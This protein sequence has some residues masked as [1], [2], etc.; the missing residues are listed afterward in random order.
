MCSLLLTSQ[1]FFIWTKYKEV[2][3][4]NSALAGSIRG[5]YCN[6]TH[7]FGKIICTEYLDLLI[8]YFSTL[9]L[10][11]KSLVLHYFLEKPRL[12]VTT[13]IRCIGNVPIWMN[14]LE[15][16]IKQH[17][18]NQSRFLKQLCQYV[19]RVKWLTVKMYL[20]LN[21]LQ[22]EVHVPLGYYDQLDLQNFE[23]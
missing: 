23:A 3:F 19:L 17:T 15:W 20:L 7:N 16:D 22:I 4:L 21:I 5:Y 2:F 6:C 12:Y 14:I 18:I 8:P 13:D 9:K 1:F 10:I 11:L